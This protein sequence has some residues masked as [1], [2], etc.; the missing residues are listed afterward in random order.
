MEINISEIIDAKLSQMDR[1]GVIKQAIEQALEKT[2]LDAVSSELGSYSLRQQIADKVR[3]QVGSVAR[4]LGLSAYNGFIA[5]RVRDI[6]RDLYTQDIAGKVQKTLSDT[7]L[8]KYD[9]F[10][11]SG[12]FEAYRKWVND[13]VD[14]EDQR[15]RG[16]YTAALDVRDDGNRKRIICR[17]AEEPDREGSPD[18]EIRFLV[19]R[20]DAKARV[21]ALYL[22]GKDMKSLVKIGVLSEF[23]ALAANLYFN[24]TKVE[25][26]IEAVGSETTFEG[27]CGY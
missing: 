12:I 21:S 26:D 22:D 3:E 4:S 11:L 5:E 27:A 18:V 9:A 2:V 16:Y 24:E 13:F 14:L 17:F 7:L 1:D 19:W 23:E 6:V 10:T 8:K 15:E 20:D 25:M